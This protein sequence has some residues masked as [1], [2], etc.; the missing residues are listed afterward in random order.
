MAHIDADRIR[1]HMESAVEHDVG[2]LAWAVSAG[3][4]LEQG[5]AGWLDPTRG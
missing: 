1:E 2:G 3:D 5:A 4:T